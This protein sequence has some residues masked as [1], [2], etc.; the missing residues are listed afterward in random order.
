MATKKLTTQGARAAKAVGGKQTPYPD[1]QVPGLELRVSASGRKAWSF[2]YRTTA[3]AQRRVSLGTFPAKDVGD[4][5]VAA[6]A[7]LGVIS[8]GGDPAADLRAAKA[9]E[10]NREI[11]SL[12][13]LAAAYFAA[14]EAGRWRPRGKVKRATTLKDET[15][16]YKRHVAPTLGK[17]DYLEVARRDVRGLLGKMIARG[18]NARTRKVHAIIR[19][20]FAWA[21]SEELLP[22]NPA[23]GL[24]PLGAQNARERVLTDPELKAFWGA[25]VDPSDLRDKAGEPV[26]VGRPMRI[27]LQL[28][29]LLLQ[30]RGEVAGMA[31]AE[32]SLDESVWLIP[33]ARAKNGKPHAVPLPPRAVVLIREAIRLGN[34]GR[35]KPSP[36]VFPSRHKAGQAF[37]PDSLT[38]AMR[39]LTD[40]LGIVG[41]APHDLRRTGSSA[42]TSERIGV[43]PYIRSRVLGH[44]SDAGGGSAV[45]SAHYD[46]NSY[47][48]EKR[49]ALC[50]WEDLVLEVVGERPRASN[51]RVLG[52]VR[53]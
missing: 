16:T 17:R 26:T 22:I 6:M 9:A 7:M 14:C 24:P 51:V 36:Y 53:A 41:V 8:G 1:G 39:D 10:A 27:A 42:L 29:T 46:A 18:I 38:H 35:E 37:R 52:E 43:S 50:A 33:G 34:E 30:R 44:T 4:A 21:L 5:R 47:L 45:S 19:Q 40:A 12:D 20:I 32:L 3:G 23:V 49:K 15:A 2:R 48:A 28:A 31:V 13:D 25:L 11:R